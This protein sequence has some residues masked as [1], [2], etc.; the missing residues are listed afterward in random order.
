MA[1]PLVSV[2]LITY[3]HEKYIHAAI[4]G[5]LSQQGIE[6]YEIVVGDDHS[7][8]RTKQILDE[9]AKSNSN[10]RFIERPANVGM[11]QNWLDTINAC[12]GK[13]VALIEG[14]DLWTDPLK[15]KKQV[16]ILEADNSL[17]V[18][19]TD[20]AVINE[21]NDGV[22]YGTYLKHQ[23]IDLKK[24]RLTSEDLCNQNFIST[25]SVMI[26]N[27]QE[28]K[29]TKEYHESPYV[30]WIILMLAALEGDLTFLSDVTCS[31]RIH[32]TGAF[33]YS[34]YELRKRNMIKV[35]RCLFFN[36]PAGKEKKLI[37]ERYLLAIEELAQHLKAVAGK[38]T[39]QFYWLKSLRKL[40]E[41]LQ[42]PMPQ[43]LF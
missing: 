6:N 3:K 31:Y 9:Y 22:E 16:E 26:R 21:M 32:P 33:G 40:A 23:D 38:S 14:D 11:H 36:L 42:S 24:T 29:V 12:E 43:K 25:V 13:Y 30:D 34:E 10:I 2:G 1:K 17:S 7:P 20:A 5:I 41:I 35:L 4:K 18:C 27:H 19:F 15:L 28:W 39:G 8:D 37:I